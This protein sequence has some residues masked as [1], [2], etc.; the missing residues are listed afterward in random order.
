MS[1]T[2]LPLREAIEKDLLTSLTITDFAMLLD[3]PDELIVRIYEG[4]SVLQ[5][6]MDLY[7]PKQKNFQA[8]A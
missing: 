6:D 1:Y 3:A 4:D 2:S 5:D 7:V 8:F